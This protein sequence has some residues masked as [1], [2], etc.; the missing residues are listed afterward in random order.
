MARLDGRPVV[1]FQVMKTKEGSEVD[2]EDGVKVELQR[3]AE[4]YPD[5]KIERVASIVDA[6]RKGL[7]ATTVVL[8]EGMVLA[9]LVVFL[10]LREWRSTLIAAVAMP[11][12]LVPTFAAMALF[13][14]SLNMLTLLALTL[15]I[16]ILVDD[17]IV[18][19]ENI[20]KRVERGL[21][22]FRAALIGGD[23]IGLAVVATTFSIVVV[24]APV[25]FMPGV[26]GQFFQEFGV[27]VA[28]S[29]LFSL[30]V[31]RLLTPLLAAYFLEGRARSQHDAAARGSRPRAGLDAA[32][33]VDVARW[34]A[35][36]SSSS[37]SGW[38]RRCPRAS[39]RTTTTASSSSS[40]AA[41]PE[42][43]ARPWSA[44]W[45]SS[46]AACTS[47]PTWSTSSR[48][49]AAT[50]TATT[51]APEPCWS[52]CA[53]IA[54]RRPTR[55]RRSCDPLCAA[56]PDALIVTQG[57]LAGSA[58]DVEIV[59]VSED[60]DA[61]EAAALRLQREICAGSR[62]SRTSAPARRRQGPELVVRPRAQE[63]A[64]LG[65][66]SETIADIV[67]V[68]TIGETDARTPKLTIGE[69]RIP[70]RVRLADS[71]AGD[72]ALLRNL[73]VPTADGGITRL[74]NVADLS[75]QAGPP[76]IERYDR[77]RQIAVQADL[78]PGYT[79]GQAT[80]AANALPAL[81]ELPA[82]R[83]QR[84]L[85]RR[86]GHVRAVQ[87]FRGRD[88]GGRPVDLRG[89]R[90]AVRRLH[91]ALRHPLRA[92]ALTR[93]RVRGARGVPHGRSSSRC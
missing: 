13:G 46:R 63:A 1:G 64:R 39:C 79:L 42:R 76:K 49:S 58:A 48:R 28:V 77:A 32:T 93:G 65:V 69:R 50:R 11:L 56:C 53:R 26:G 41:R 92:A 90:A 35:S 4:A 34:R 82:R 67:R 54:R 16:G 89:A 7:A 71:Q 22:P 9:A 52:C 38:R 80:A 21:T 78:A 88:G 37:R 45:R 40:S 31:A 24:F 27:T 29:V 66:A 44:A 33:P 19:I 14:F 55:S 73:P 20:Q 36:R 47:T 74:A 68:T 25:S 8:L 62:A 57:G 5:V 30:V 91:Q 70:V 23:A 72:L 85:R 6:T 87:R 75:F 86:R 61:L 12:S 60:P 10:F 43:C 59:L 83:A 3:V 2:V 18:E 15:V 84:G 51:C 17:A 81:R